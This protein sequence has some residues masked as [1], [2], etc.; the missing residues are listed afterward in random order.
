[1]NPAIFFE[2]ITVS[3][4]SRLKAA[5][6]SSGEH[7]TARIVSTHSRLK[8]AGKPDDGKKPDDGFQHTAA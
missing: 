2:F 1:M 8:A 6:R 4:H 5:G 7:E 3:T